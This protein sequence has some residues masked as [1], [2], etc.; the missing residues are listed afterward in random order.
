MM[1]VLYSCSGEDRELTI[2]NQEED[3]D[4]YV[5]SLR[6]GTEVVNNGGAIRVVVTPGEGEELA[7]AGDSIYFY[8]ACYS[9]SGSKGKGT[10]YSTNS[11]EVADEENFIVVGE[12]EKRVIGDDDFILGLSNGL[13]GTKVG[14]NCNIFFSAKYGYNSDAVYNIPPLSPLFFDI[15]IERIIKN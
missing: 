1:L 3:I 8:Y 14:E 13:I 11:S 15:W 5:T 4:E 10:L 7:E 6:E 12:V 2:A 9:F